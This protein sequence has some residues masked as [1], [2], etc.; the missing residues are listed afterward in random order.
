MLYAYHV[1]TQT[2]AY[3][4]HLSLPHVSQTPA[5]LLAVVRA[6]SR[7]MSGVHVIECCCSIGA[8]GRHSLC[9]VTPG[10]QVTASI[11]AAGR[12]TTAV[13]TVPLAVEIRLLQLFFAVLRWPASYA[14]FWALTASVTS[15]ALVPLPSPPRSITKRAHDQAALPSIA[16]RSNGNR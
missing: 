10:A 8:R 3:A 14:V 6:C 16:G 11:A 5:F 4:G 7:P 2:S 13:C 15:L 1:N 12:Q 9:V